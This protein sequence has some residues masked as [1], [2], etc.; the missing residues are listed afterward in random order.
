MRISPKTIK[1]AFTQKLFHK[2]SSHLMSI[3]SHL[4]SRNSQYKDENTPFLC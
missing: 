1:I 2:T 4:M 3:N